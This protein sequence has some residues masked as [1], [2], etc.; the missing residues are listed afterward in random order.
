LTFA[1]K[2][3]AIRALP[4]TQAPLLLGKGTVAVA[5]AEGLVNVAPVN[6]K[7]FIVP[8]SL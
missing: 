8:P 6:G 3:P 1:E 5:A 4:A 2:L 7:R